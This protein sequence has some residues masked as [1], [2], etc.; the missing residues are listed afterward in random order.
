[1]SAG[2]TGPVS[3]SG[4]DTLDGALADIRA[5]RSMPEFTDRA[6]ELALLGCEADAVALGRIADEVWAPWLQAGR[7]G[8]LQSGGALP[9]GPV[10]VDDAPAL[11]RQVIRSR[12]TGSRELA[13]APDVRRV[14][15]AAVVAGNHVLG[16]LH[17]VGGANLMPEIVQTCAGTL[18]SVMGLLAVRQRAEE[19]SYVLAKLRNGLSEPPERPIELLA[20]A[21]GPRT[22]TASSHPQ[23][24]P[25]GP[26]DRLT[27]RQREVLDL[28]LGGLSNAEIAERLVLAVPTVKSHVRAV[29]R[30]SGA[31]NRSDAVARFADTRD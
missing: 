18:G 1:V 7:E 19:Q 22:A 26:G 17:V 12:R 23:L 14:V 5:C 28:M 20:A 2:E 10:A 16:L 4:W 25:L 21:P 6:C 13:P 9:P 15:L 30:A 8:L 11:E 27:A 24:D 31:V 3:R 29:L